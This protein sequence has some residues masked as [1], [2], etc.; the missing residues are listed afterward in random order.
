MLVRVGTDR[1]THSHAWTN[2]QALTAAV[3]AVRCL[4]WADWKVFSREAVWH[5]LK[6]RQKVLFCVFRLFLGLCRTASQPYRLSHI[7]TFRINQFYYSKD[8]KYWEL[9]KLEND[10]FLGGHFEFFLTL[11]KFLEALGSGIGTCSVFC[12]SFSHLNNVLG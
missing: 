3:A 12:H 2:A 11:G 7:N 9:A 4:T 1:R 6:N 10:L 5:K 8:K